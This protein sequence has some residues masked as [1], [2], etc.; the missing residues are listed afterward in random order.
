MP[1]SESCFDRKKLVFSVGLKLLWLP[2]TLAVHS[3]GPHKNL[4]HFLKHH[5]RK[6]IWHGGQEDGHARVGEAVSRVFRMVTD[7]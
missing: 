1:A 5:R 4:L 7:S 3:F 6:M 2:M